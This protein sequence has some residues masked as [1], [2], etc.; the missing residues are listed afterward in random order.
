MATMSI[1]GGARMSVAYMSTETE[2]WLDARR[3]AFVQDVLAAFTHRP[4]DLLPFEEVHH[5]LH[6]SNMRYLGLQEVPVDHIVGSVGRYQ[7]FTRAFLPR[8]ENL[9]ER[10]RRIDQL[11]TSGAGMPPI[12]LYQVGQAY[13]VRDGNHRVS[14]ARQHHIPSIE[15][16][17]WEYTT[18]IPLE[19]DS[20]VDQVLCQA[21]HGAFAGRTRVDRLCPDLHIEITQPGGYEELLHEIEAFQGILSE[22]DNQ[23]IPYDRAVALWCEMRYAPIVE[24]IRQGDI[25]HEFPGRT[26]ADL[27]L[28]LVRNQAELQTSHGGHTLLEDAADDMGKHLGKKVGLSHHIRRGARWMAYAVVV[29]ADAWRR[30]SRRALR[31]EE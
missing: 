17:V 26:E 29:R 8:R 12:E 3:N 31:R 24:I 11:V 15:A 10:W 5:K 18:D 13:F 14:V 25:L 22:I 2:D 30:A 23:E 28:W 20:D 27:Y 1:F 9:G 6:L 16:Y 19:P 21:A 4:A 7:D